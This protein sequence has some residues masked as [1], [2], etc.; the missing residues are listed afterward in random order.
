MLNLR[1]IDLNLLPVFEA[2]YEEGSLS[3]AARRLSL[4][5]PAVS[6]ALAR[7]RAT[8]GDELFVRQSRG[9]RPTPAADALYGR[10]RE[11]LA[12][13]RGAIDESR[14]F[15]PATSRRRFTVAI[16]HPLGPLLAVRLME[17]L[18]SVAPGV[19]V[20]FS[21]RSRPLD[22]DKDLAAGRFDLAL[23]WLAPRAGSLTADPVFTEG[24]AAMVRSGHPALAGGK[25]RPPVVGWPLVRLRPRTDWSALPVGGVKEWLALGLRVGLEVSEM[26]EVLAV[27]SRSDMVGI[28]PTS[29]ASIARRDFG[30][31]AVPG[32][33]A[34]PSIPVWMV[35]REARRAEPSHAFLRERLA[36]AVRDFVA[37]AQP[38]TRAGK[39]RMPVSKVRTARAKS[40]GLEP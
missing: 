9:M 33:P 39:G 30:L 24:I 11:A 25:R 23:D 36:A 17:S 7:L 26:L 37:G 13:V 8:F 18:A 5:Q 20:V 10:V 12:I 28:V 29:L 21:T 34:S 38:P 4:T 14:G 32:L 16:P 2:A 19:E 35:Y 22:L 3:G 15:D 40:S 6:H 1:A 27:A 31:E